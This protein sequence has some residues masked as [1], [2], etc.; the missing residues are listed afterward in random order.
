MNLRKLV[1][2]TIEE[3]KTVRDI[4]VTFSFTDMDLRDDET[5]EFYEA[6][7][8]LEINEEDE[9]PENTSNTI[10]H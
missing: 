8:P 2:D 9:E 4:T 7:K 1:K 10:I 5:R 6:I 3:T